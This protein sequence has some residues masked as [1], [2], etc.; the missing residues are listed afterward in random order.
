[1][2]K[3]KL[4]LII[5]FC[6]IIVGLL[7]FLLY[8]I[9]N[10]SGGNK[11]QTIFIFSPNEVKQLLQKTAEIYDVNG[12]MSTGQFS[13]NSYAIL[14][15]PGTYDLNGGEIKIG[16]YT[17]ILGIGSS[18]NS[19]VVKG[20]ISVPN[21]PDASN[22]LNNFWRGCENLTITN[23]S[24]SCGKKTCTVL[25]S[26]QACSYRSLIINSDLYLHDNNT[27]VSGGFIA[28]CKI[29]GQLQPSSQQQYMFRSIEMDDI[30]NDAVWNYVFAGC[31]VNSRPIFKPSCDKSV[32][33]LSTK[34]YRRI[35][36][37]FI[38]SSSANLTD[39]NIYEPNEEADLSKFFIENFD[40]SNC[41]II[42]SDKIGFVSPSNNVD[43]INALISSKDAILFTPGVYAIDKTI[44]IQGKLLY[45]VGLPKLQSINGSVP[46]LSG[47]G[48]ICGIICKSA[49]KLNNT[50]TL[51]KITGDSNIWDVYCM[52]G[53]DDSTK[54]YSTNTMM[55]IENCSQC[56]IENIWLWL[57]DHNNVG[58]TNWDNTKCNYGLHVKNTA[59][60]VLIYGLFSEHNH[61]RN[62][63]WEGKNGMV[64]MYQSEFNY[65]YPENA[66]DIVSYEVT[67]S[68]HKIYGGGAYSVTRTPY[69]AQAG[70]RFP[71]DT[72][73]Q[74][75]VIVAICSTY[76]GG[77]SNIIDGDRK[78]AMI[79][80]TTECPGI[81]LSNTCQ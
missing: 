77:I 27:Y 8:E 65:D 70:F 61:V 46:V 56:Y 62:V 2:K 51:I 18:P 28:N 17:Q 47:N 49:E 4:I 74:N 54:N 37:P 53:G 79:N 73:S 35:E 6:I 11:T 31:K 24:R 29:T 21:P 71:K 33:G 1:M 32:M 15:L 22:G 80:N 5:F 10:K 52:V 25:A 19:V 30:L 76:Y 60:N 66:K 26:S 42:S 14:L 59:N 38:V 9:F 20:S 81:K 40:K 34:L 75:L 78:S 41:K 67:G 55:S 44:N 57:A 45:G 16:Y 69:T 72:A 43:Q 13:K 63:L 68:E 3:Y 48:R 39:I 36:K 23:P 58:P 7:S 50:N 64:Y 12:L